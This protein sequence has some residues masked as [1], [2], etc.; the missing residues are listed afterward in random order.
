MSTLTKIF[1]ILIFMISVG[2][3]AIVAAL[4]GQRED[5]HDKYE[6]EV[7]QHWAN[8]QMLRA[9]TEARE[10]QIV[11]LNREIDAFK[12]RVEALRGEVD[13][14]ET[15]V[16]TLNRQLVDLSGK[17]TQTLTQMEGLNQ[18]LSLLVSRQKE[19]QEANDKLRIL[20]N[21]AVAERQQAQTELV[22]LKGKSDALMGQLEALEKQYIDVAREAKQRQDQIDDVIRRGITI[23]VLPAPRLDA[24]VRGTA[25][26]LGL[27]VLSRG[28][29]DGVRA[30]MN[31]TVFRGPQFVC[32][33]AVEKVERAWCSGRIV[34]KQ[35]DPIVG[36]D[37]TN[38]INR[39]G[40]GAGK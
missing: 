1:V 3:V 4:Y 30:G 18:N 5:W 33:V 26:E 19:L 27:V 29:D 7:N 2:T 38:D 32:K 20:A 15:L 11:T 35:M 23:D 17:F 39:A 10:I 6:K 24:K 16:A 28:A 14:K 8:V 31:F 9:E 37:A 22:D 25:P 34:V 36:D 21:E 13:A 40:L 12:Q